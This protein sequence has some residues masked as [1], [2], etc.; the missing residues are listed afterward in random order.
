MISLNGCARQEYDGIDATTSLRKAAFGEPPGF[1]RPG[2]A[3][4]PDACRASHVEAPAAPEVREG[5]AFRR[6]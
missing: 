3:E 6:C 4:V 2:A 1:A 5:A